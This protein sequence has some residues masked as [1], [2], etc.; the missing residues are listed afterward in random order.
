MKLNKYTK[1]CQ[2]PAFGVIAQNLICKWQEEFISTH[3]YLEFWTRREWL[4]FFIN[5]NL[6]N[7]AITSYKG[8]RET[9][10][11]GGMYKEGSQ[12]HSG[13]VGHSRSANQRSRNSIE[14]NNRELLS[15]VGVSSTYRC[16]YIPVGWKVSE[17][18]WC[19]GGAQI[20]SFWS[21]SELLR[22]L[23]AVYLLLIIQS[24]ITPSCYL[25]FTFT[26]S[27]LIPPQPN[28]PTLPNNMF[29]RWF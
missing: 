25:P 9:E 2:A 3:S 16:T 15:L 17:G 1:N 14:V 8:V 6:H 21:D 13:E 12:R 24:P 4:T 11:R 28:R 10:S 20:E 5:K 23:L 27:P 18:R 22:S 19:A 29:T 7:K 26:A